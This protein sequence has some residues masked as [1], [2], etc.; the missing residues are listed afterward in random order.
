MQLLTL[1]IEIHKPVAYTTDITGTAAVK[2]EAP[3]LPRVQEFMMK[4]GL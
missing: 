3:Q 1:H 2:F 4:H